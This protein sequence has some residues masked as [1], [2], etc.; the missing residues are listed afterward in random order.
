MCKFLRAAPESSSC[1]PGSREI[2]LLLSASKPIILFFSK[3]GDQPEF[4]WSIFKSFSIPFSPS[5][6]IGL[7]SSKENKNFSCSVPI[8]QS[9][10]FFSLCLKKSTSCD[11][12]WIASLSFIFNSNHQILIDNMRHLILQLYLIAKLLGLKKLI[13]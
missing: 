13:V 10:F 5:Y 11:F 7:K 3:I 8:N 6:G 12:E 4:S 1:P 9:F 2:E